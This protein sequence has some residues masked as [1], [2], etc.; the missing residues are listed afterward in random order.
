MET[1]LRTKELTKRYHK[2]WAV[3]HVTL[4]IQKGDIF[5]FV[6]ANGAGKTTFMRM[7][8]GLIRPTEGEL[9]LFGASSPKELQSMRRRMGALIEHPALYANMTA[10]QNLDVQRRYL[11][12]D[13]GGQPKKALREILELVGLAEA[14]DKKAG[15]FSLG[16]RQR[17]GLA[18]A[19]VG[20]PEFII[21][22]EPTIGLDP[23]G[24]MELR[25]LVLKLNQERKMTILFSSHNLAE[26]AQIAT[27]YGFL[28]RGRLLE[29]ISGEKI[30]RVCQER[31]INLENYFVELLLEHRGAERRG[32]GDNG[33][34][35]GPGGSAAGS[36]AGT[37]GT[38]AEG[39]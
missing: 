18:M 11:G 14:A 35:W 34:G 2:V 30:G 9:E 8:C 3:D 15:R 5:G 20:D 29:V 19:L 10:L 38:E 17:L 33:N 6:G 1:I 26:M 16:M 25:R 36:S 23:I 24:V 12:M 39:K 13:F 32:A 4:S 21:L 27:K 31:G 37:V 28:D 7:V 22:D